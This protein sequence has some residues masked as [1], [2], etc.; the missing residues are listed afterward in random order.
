MKSFYTKL[1][2]HLSEHSSKRLP[3]KYANQLPGKLKKFVCT[4]QGALIVAPGT[5]GLTIAIQ[6]LGLLQPLE[7]AALDLSFRLRPPEP[8]DERIIIVGVKESDLAT[9]KQYPASDAVLA[10]LLNRIKQQQPKVI[11]LD[12]YRDLPVEPGYEELVK[13]FKS[14]PNLIGIKK[15]IGDNYNSPVAPPPVLA[16]LD[17]VSSN[18]VVVDFDAVLRR[19]MLF[20]EP[21]ESLQ[22]LG[23]AVATTYLQHKGLEPEA[24]ENGFM[25]IGNTVFKPF[26]A[27]DG[28]YVRADDGS[29]QIL[30][31]FRGGANNFRSVSLIDVLENR[32]PPDLM[33]NR[34]VLI[35]AKAISLNDA[36]YTPYSRT[37]QTTPVR[38][39]GV[40][41]QANL[42]SQVLSSVLDGRPL[43]QVWQEPVEKSWIFL[44]AL[45]IASF[46]WK[47]R[48]QRAHFF[49]IKTITL[50]LV[51]LASISLIGYGSFLL[52]WWIPVISPILGVFASTIGISS[53]V[54][55]NRLKELNKILEQTNA[56][57]AE[58]NIQLE[59]SNSE[60]E[61]TNIQLE[62]SNNQL[63]VANLK[64]EQTVGEL[65]KV[66]CDLKESQIQLIQSEKMSTLGQLVAGVAHEINN[67]IGFI[68]GNVQCLEG[69][70]Q[71]LT[72]HLL[73]YQEVF[74]NPGDQIEENAEEIDIDY[75]LEDMPKMV[76][77]MQIG[78]KRIKEI[79][80]SLRTFS[81]SDTAS[82]TICNI[83]E[84]IDS[85]ILIL[86]H[87]LKASSE[88][89][90]I[91]IIKEYGK[92]PDVNCYPGQLN[93]VIM[94]L[95]SN[96]IDALEE[97][98]Q[99][100]SF[101]EIEAN[102][103][104][105]TIITELLADKKMVAIHIKDNGPGMSEEVKQ[106]IFEHLFTTK[107]VGKGTGL[108]LSISRQIV[109]E[110][111]SGK[112]SCVSSLGSGAEFIIEI[113]V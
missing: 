39:A 37:F 107:N 50:L 30:L 17:Q 64:L 48:S 19:G 106:K 61:K 63:E 36:F 47:W 78:V 25:K 88:R 58:T 49:L 93:Q 108:G 79:S 84:G 85:T 35:G 15:I 90:E 53:Y 46:C 95:I 42:A 45:L 76:D 87:R 105:I 38:T 101:K 57:L 62:Q 112:L 102:P 66:L 113:P 68:S 23:L 40:E 7:L 110:A 98:N 9:L 16:E 111:H 33:R 59:S 70:V 60:L 2:K 1:Y 11:G 99:G 10:K 82:K 43:I 41:I 96:A 65:E 67:P 44:W 24:A 92:L 77:S 97:S 86:K 56:Q 28:G 4:W 71:D 75:V 81:R 3:A 18:D 27:N 20:P 74:P 104:K 31:N 22:S 12:L 109:E 34:I 55:I 26:K 100:K 8:I 72:N 54:Y 83:H 80:I 5:A 94:N 21:G 52:G 103:N 13:V 69:Y 14:T 89:P 73:L 91:E 51:S 6:F 32:I 29:Y